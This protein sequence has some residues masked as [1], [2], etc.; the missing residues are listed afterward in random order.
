MLYMI[1]KYVRPFMKL[2]N[3]IKKNMAKTKETE[4]LT[5]S[6]DYPPAGIAAAELI[7][8][9]SEGRTLPAT[10]TE[11]QLVEFLGQ[12]Q[13]RL[14]DNL[15]YVTAAKTI[16][17]KSSVVAQKKDE[18]PPAPPAPEAEASWS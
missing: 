8:A 4:P 1:R 13:N 14:A 12:I 17:E 16:I 7:I 6:S 9:R 2:L 10:L 11:A 5:P 3:R 18:P 15:L